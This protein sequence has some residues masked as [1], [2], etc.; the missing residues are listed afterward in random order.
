MHQHHNENH[1]LCLP[2]VHIIVREL[3]AVR[4]MAEEKA[5]REGEGWMGGKLSGAGLL[6]GAPAPEHQGRAE[7]RA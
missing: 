4:E 6:T 5:E 3:S 7:R 1:S 2:G